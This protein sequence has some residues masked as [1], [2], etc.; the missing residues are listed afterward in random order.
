[1]SFII[2]DF[3]TAREFFAS[4]AE[5]TFLSYDNTR[6]RYRAQHERRRNGH[7]K[8]GM[9][10]FVFSH[11]YL[12]FLKNK[13]KEVFFLFHEKSGFYYAKASKQS[14]IKTLLLIRKGNE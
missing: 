11:P 1:M 7:I 13:R 4:I 10:S 6:G 2:G 3:S 8:A 12:N 5:I 14:Y 9:K